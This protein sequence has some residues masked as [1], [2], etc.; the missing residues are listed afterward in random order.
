ML[1]E[2]RGFRVDQFCFAVFRLDLAALG[3]D[4]RPLLARDFQEL[5][6][7]LPVHVQIV[8]HQVVERIPRHLPR[9]HVIHQPREIVG[10]RESCGRTMGDQRSAAF[11]PHALRAGPS[12]HQLGE[13]DPSLE[14][15]QCLRQFQC[16]GRSRPGGALGEQDLVF[17]DVSQCDDA[18]QDRGVNF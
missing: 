14:S 9:D 15:A 7:K 5:Q 12:E 16:I 2:P 18:R 3:Q 4:G 17:V 10:E 13:Q 8:R 11:A 6:C 1:G